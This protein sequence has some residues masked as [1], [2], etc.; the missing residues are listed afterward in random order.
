MTLIHQIVELIISHHISISLFKSVYSKIE[1]QV[2]RNHTLKPFNKPSNNL[3]TSSNQN[4]YSKENSECIVSSIP[5][6]SPISKKDR[7]MLS[8]EINFLIDSLISPHKENENNCFSFSQ[9][10]QSPPKKTMKKTRSQLVP[11]TK[12][13]IEKKEKLNS[14]SAAE[15]SSTSGFSQYS[16]INS[17]SQYLAGQILHQK[18]TNS[19]NSVFELSKQE[20]EEIFHQLG[21]LDRNEK[22]NDRAVFRETLKSWELDENVFDAIAIQNEILQAINGDID[23]KFRKLVRNRIN[24]HLSNKKSPKFPYV[25][26]AKYTGSNILS[27]DV[28]DRLCAPIPEPPEEEMPKAFVYSKNSE[29]IIQ[30]SGFGNSDFSTRTEYFNNRKKFEQMKIK[31]QL[32]EERIPAKP[33]NRKEMRQISEHLTN[34]PHNSKIEPVVINTS[35]KFYCSYDEYCQ[36]RDKLNERH[37]N[38]PNLPGWTSHYRRMNKAQNQKIQKERDEDNYSHLHVPIIKYR[39]KKDNNA[40]K[41]DVYRI[42]YPQNRFHIEPIRKKKSHKTSDNLNS[43]KS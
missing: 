31:S 29:E 20:V 14:S 30:S 23:T 42:Q 6:E 17:N 16:H 13:M 32:Q 19:F 39:P 9:T 15:S 10:N 7:F 4:I 2:S 25:P 12:S 21:I 3:S 5:P 33:G 22:I 8:S 41:I 24:V 27:Y 34:S 11:M 28:F 35:P 18:V 40:E 38:E 37:S 36:Y 1:E 43:G 26:T